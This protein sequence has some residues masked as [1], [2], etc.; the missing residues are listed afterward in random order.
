MNQHIIQGRS[1]DLGGGG[2]K[3]NFFS[4]LEICMS[5][6]ECAL[7]GGFVGMSPWENYL[8]WC[9]L[10]RF[11]VYFDPILSLKIFKKYYFL[12]KKI[13]IFDT[14]L[15]LLIE[16]FLKTCYVWWVLVYILKEFWK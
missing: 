6:S 12:Y 15:V 8:K 2:A 3:N 16:K 4:D 13:N 9:N 14:R 5:R 11:G 1:Q 10:V 7:L